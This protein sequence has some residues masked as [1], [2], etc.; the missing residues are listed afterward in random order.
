MATEADNTTTTEEQ[1]SEQD[2]EALDEETAAKTAAAAV[3]ELLAE[4]TGAEEGGEGQ[5]APT[6]TA[7]EE[8]TGEHEQP[9]LSEQ[10]TQAAK[11]LGYSDDEIAD[12]TPEVAEG[13]LH[14]SQ[15]VRK[16]ESE[17]GRRQQELEA[18]ASGKET[19]AGKSAEEGI[20][21]DAPTESDLDFGEEASADGEL[22]PIVGTVNTT[23][24]AV[25]D[26]DRRLREYEGRLRSAET[27]QEDAAQAVVNEKVKVEV[28][29]Y[30][31]GLDKEKWPQFGEGS[32]DSLGKDTAE[33]VARQAVMDRATA[34]M[35]GYEEA[36]IEMSVADCLDQATYSLYKAELQKAAAKPAED[37]KKRVK[38]TGVAR[39]TGSRR[40]PAEPESDEVRAARAIAEK[41][42]AE[43]IPVDA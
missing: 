40:P 36:D 37:A 14:G 7:G 21:A 18:A 8:P 32:F 13:L 15:R 24:K 11:H 31:A 34:I 12:L 20:V 43:G 35:G 4:Q 10:H 26:V 19:P 23:R 38:A 29:E 33:K 25:M 30:F 41:A 42:R 17:L 2:T 28:D 6:E 22:D 1:V 3:D 39:P 9:T 16:K 27:R 5:E